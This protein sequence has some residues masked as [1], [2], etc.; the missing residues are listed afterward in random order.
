VDAQLKT[1]DSILLSV[2][3]DQNFASSA[4]ILAWIARADGAGSTQQLAAV[5]QFTARF[6]LGNHVEQ[7]IGLTHPISIPCLQLACALLQ[8]K[9]VQNQKEAL[10]ELACGVA[11]ADGYLSISELVILRFLSGLFGYT[12]DGFDMIAERS[13]GFS[14][15]TLGDPGSLRWWT[16]V[17]TT[18]SEQSSSRPIMNRDLSR[19]K[20]LAVLGLDEKASV[21]DIKRA[22]RRLSQV[23]H[24]DR[25]MNSGPEAVAAATES[26]KRIHAAYDFFIPK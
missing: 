7:L 5:R 11:V 24:P 14:P 9:M 23:H 4:L 2:G 19:L 20:A 13:I 10:L 12:V 21:E 16:K 6:K 22:Y 3:V 17:E 18:R 15:A 1:F 8:S 25:F 26:F